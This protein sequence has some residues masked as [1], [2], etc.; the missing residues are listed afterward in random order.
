MSPQKSE[1]QPKLQKYKSRVVL[2][3]IVKDDSGACAVL[4]ERGSSASQM[5]AA[6]ILDAIARLPSC[7]G[8]VADAIWAFAQVKLEDAPR[9]LKIP[10][11]ED[12]FSTTHVAKIMG[13]H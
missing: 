13:K 9:L 11:T 2:Q 8:Q 6:K 5:T 3:D 1:L 7:D 12:T 10:E 4:T